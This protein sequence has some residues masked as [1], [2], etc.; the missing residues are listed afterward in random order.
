MCIELGFGENTLHKNIE[1]MTLKY[2]EEAA[3]LTALKLVGNEATHSDGIDEADLL[4]S[5]KIFEAALHIFKK[6]KLSE[7][8]AKTIP[9]IE[10]KFLK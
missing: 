6:R 7:A 8:V 10:Q 4:D 2:P 5:F 1:A 3:W 9:K